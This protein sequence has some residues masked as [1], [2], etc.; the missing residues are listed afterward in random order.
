MTALFVVLPSEYEPVTQKRALEF[1]LSTDMIKELRSLTSVDEQ[2]CVY[3]CVSECAGV[4]V[5]GRR[6]GGSVGSLSGSRSDLS[7]LRVYVFFCIEMRHLTSVC[8]YVC[9]CVCVCVCV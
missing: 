3:V 5:C 8:V 2:V 6:C 1:L 7:V 4:R 9:A